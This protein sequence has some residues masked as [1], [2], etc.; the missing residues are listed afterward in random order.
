[1]LY[2]TQLRKRIFKLENE[3]IQE[4]VQIHGQWCSMKKRLVNPKVIFK[5]FL[6]GITVGLIF[7][8]KRSAKTS[9]AKTISMPVIADRP[10]HFVKKFVSTLAFDVLL[11]FFKVRLNNLLK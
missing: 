1:M 5:S 7:M 2:T 3:M 10:F 8:H 6:T 9:L 4:K 11:N